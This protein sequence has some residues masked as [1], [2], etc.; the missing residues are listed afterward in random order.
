MT[1][2]S[3]AGNSFPS[4][5]TS[6]TVALPDHLAD[7]NELVAFVFF[8]DGSASGLSISPPAGWTTITTNTVN[9]PGGRVMGAYA[10]TITTAASEPADY[11]WTYS[12][13]SAGTA[14]VVLQYT[15]SVVDGFGTGANSASSTSTS[16]IANPFTAG[17]TGDTT[18]IAVAEKNDNPTNPYAVGTT[19]R[20]G[21]NANGF[22]GPAVYVSDYSP[23]T[24][25]SIASYFGTF[26]K[27]SYWN[28][29]CVALQPTAGPGGGPTGT[30]TLA[31]GPLSFTVGAG[32]VPPVITS[33]TITGTAVLA[34]GP[35]TISASDTILTRT[36]TA[37]LPLGPV[38]VVSVAASIGPGARPVPGYRGRWRL[39]LHQRA[40]TAKTLAQTIIAEL[41]DARGRR[42]DQ[43]WN[44]PAQ[45]TFTLDGQSESAGLIGELLHDVVAWRWDDQTG[46]DFPVFRG[47][48][49]Q[50]EDQLT[51][52]SHAVTY[53]CHD[54]AALLSRRIT[55][56]TYTVTGRDQDL[57]VGDLLGLATG[58]ASSSGTSFATAAFLPVSLFT[59]N[60]DGSLRGL[61]TRLR[62]R[63]YYG[64]QNIGEAVDKLAQVANG[65]D[66]DVL[67]SPV[68][69]H[70]NL[71]VFYPQQG[72]TRSDVFLQYGSTVA[73]LTRSVNS[74]DYANYVRVLGNNQS[75][76]PTPQL[77]GEAWTS[78]ATSLATP[79]GL[80]MLGDDAADVTV[81]SHLTEKANGD[82][83]LDALVPTYTL[84]LSPD[85]YEWG[86][87]N[88]GDVVPLVVQS[89]R[90]NV[91]TTVRV[92]GISY[93]IGDDGQEDVIL[94][95][96]RPGASLARLLK[97]SEQNVKSLTRR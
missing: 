8:F 2:V 21:T 93:S 60:P 88:M 47:P 24:S 7:G 45:L 32:G 79:V 27:A 76:N 74:A 33:P 81:A 54:Y 94:T 66:Y 64:S 86:K 90:L 15:F 4:G 50:S 12:G 10:H 85:A 17:H 43:I 29:I 37:S 53:T 69:D 68:D 39:T 46:V 16:W 61:S 48:I 20:R 89:G 22:D 77:Y 13:A 80:W 35:L 52:Q 57:I 6:V 83:A 14:A 92:V 9:G 65:F 67:P 78:D 75:A 19:P 11:T 34:L 97:K 44:T 84:T 31:L 18:V 5:R 91:N 36:G 49:T 87:P 42:L 1:Y 51:E 41:A 23:E 28:A 96:A 58:A 3:A 63:T 55:T 62:D 30:A 72:V 71:R 82:L 59:A 56:S 26:D 70:D 73:A 40:F 95:V 38:R 25:T